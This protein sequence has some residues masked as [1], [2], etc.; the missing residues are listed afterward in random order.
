MEKEELIQILK[1]GEHISLE[2][3]EASNEIPK[4]VWETYSAFANTEGGT[5]LL[6]I[7]EN[8]KETDLNKRFLVTGM[9]NPDR[10]RGDFWSTV[11]S[12]KVSANILL[13]QDVELVEADDRTIMAIRVP[14]ADYKHRPVY[15]NGNPMKGSFRRNYE[16]DYHCSEDEVRQMLHD[17]SESGTDGRLLEGYTMDDIDPDSIR[18]YRMEYENKNP[19]HV[20]NTIDDKE[21]LRNIGGYVR[22]RR[23]GKEGLTAAGL[24]M[25]GKGLSVREYF[26][27]LSLDYL[28]KTNLQGNQRWADRLTID[29]TWENNLYSF[30]RKVIPKLQDGLKKP[31]RIEGMTRIDDTG[32]HQAIREAVI[33]MVI[34]ADYQISGRLF[35]ERDDNGYL[36]SNPGNLKIPAENIFE[37]GHTAARNPKIQMMF[38]MIGLCDNIGSGFPM[39]LKVWEENDWRK[40][41][42]YDDL[43]LRTVELRLWTCEA[44]P[45]EI[46]A[47]LIQF[48]G[49]KFSILSDSE[50]IILSSAYMEDK[51]GIK[52]LRAA[53][54]ADTGEIQDMLTRLTEQEFLVQIRQSNRISYEINK[55]YSYSETNAREKVKSKEGYGATDLSD[56]TSKDLELLALFDGTS[57]LTNRQI[58]EEIESINTVQGAA[59]AMQRLIE[60]GIV[61]QYKVGRQNKYQKVNNKENQL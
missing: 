25:F 42:F 31:F 44:I 2:C 54:H 26:D 11:N 40:P 14:R 45:A 51:V 55:N 56:L 28:D 5:I 1:N 58:I 41:D 46:E 16:G 6:G 9:K 30:V 36:F 37:G 32:L 20:W 50:K 48:F 38:R 18:A 19:G 12:E 33:N 17:S 52:R 43:D 29:G 10:R 3:K 4:S 47:I 23:S 13:D 27:T 59:K 35:V 61:R 39:I 53:L 49:N 34:H 15:I 24:L 7:K 22:D 57:E 21:F 60:K 8:I